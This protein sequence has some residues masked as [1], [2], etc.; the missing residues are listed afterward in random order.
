MQIR[1][2]VKFSIKAYVVVYSRTDVE[3]GT[4]VGDIWVT[5]EGEKK[6]VYW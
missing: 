4:E 6:H 5:V 2:G 3:S 1:D